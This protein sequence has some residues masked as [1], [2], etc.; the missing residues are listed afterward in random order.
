MAGKAFQ[1]GFQMMMRMMQMQQGQQ[2]QEQRGRFM[3]S[4]I[5]GEQFKRRQ[6]LEKQ[7]RMDEFME[8]TQPTTG[9]APGALESYDPFLTPGIPGGMV[10]ETPS[11]MM[12]DP[13]MLARELMGLEQFGAA[14]TLMGQAK[15]RP[16]KLSFENL[17]TRYLAAGFPVPEAI[18]KAY[19]EFQ[20]AKKV[21]KTS[22]TIGGKV[23]PGAQ[24][25]KT[26][27][28]QN[29]GN[30]LD[31]IDKNWEAAF[32]GPVE[33]RA[34]AVADKFGLDP[35]KIFGPK[36]S[37]EK[38]YKEIVF[39]QLTKQLG[40][41]ILRLRSGAQIN[42]QEM[43]RMMGWLPDVNS[44]DDVFRARLATLKQ[45]FDEIAA[46]RTKAFGQAGYKAPSKP[47]AGEMGKYR[48]MLDK[49]LKTITRTGVDKK[50]GKKVI[51]YSDGSIEYGE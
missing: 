48:K 30:M 15:T 25:E 1:R 11:P 21:P 10:E 34:G 3:E 31:R 32:T 20:A 9:V 29:F 50:T 18:S 41:D 45:T 24:V 22:I 37:T 26:A 14:A 49:K 28:L 8:K 5:R 46:T 33:G 42:E 12:Q 44:P 38:R 4:Q 27:A 40:D 7:L 47:S 13:R 36:I 35:R 17:M 51:Q 19:K 16:E 6:A 39:R 43:K 2:A 23:M